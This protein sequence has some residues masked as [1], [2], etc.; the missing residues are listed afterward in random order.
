MLYPAQLHRDELKKKL[1][2]CWYDPKY[3]WYFGG[4][5]HEFTIP[6]NTDYR[7]DFVHLDENGEVDGFFS[8]NYEDGSKSMRQFGLVSFGD[9]G[10]ALIGD[11]ISQ[12]K[13]M[14][15][16]GAQR[17][18][19]WAFADNPVCKFYDKLAARYGG[20]RVGML[21]RSAYFNGKYHDVVFYEFLVENYDWGRV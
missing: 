4:E 11:A 5:R 16:N 6:D 21:T 12:V 8:Y 19:F 1:I 20:A 14:F 13:M 2:S 10:A 3:E 18:E 9:N 15:A 7:Q 17:C